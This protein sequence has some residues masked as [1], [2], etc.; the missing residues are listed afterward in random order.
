[1]TNVLPEACSLP[2]FEPRVLMQVGAGCIAGG[3]LASLS[4]QRLDGT[5]DRECRSSPTTLFMLRRSRGSLH[6]VKNT[7][8]NPTQLPTTPKAEYELVNIN[9]KNSNFAPKTSW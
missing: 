1:M 3:D 9:G 5:M 7:T 2:P 4:D 8:K 6:D